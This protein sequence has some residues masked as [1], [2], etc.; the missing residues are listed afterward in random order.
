ML[1][2]RRLFL[3]FFFL[4]LTVFV[5]NI[6]SFQFS[7]RLLNSRTQMKWKKTNQIFNTFWQRIDV[8][9]DAVYRQCIYFIYKIYLDETEQKKERKKERQRDRE[10][11]EIEKGEELALLFAVVVV[12]AVYIFCRNEKSLRHLWHFNEFDKFFQTSLLDT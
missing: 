9:N 4:R 11:G 10:K 6:H 3:F 12:V 5:F 7:H 8:Y 1:C 2:K